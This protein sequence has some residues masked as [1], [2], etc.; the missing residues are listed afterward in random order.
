MSKKEKNLLFLVAAVAL[1]AVFWF[2]LYTPLDNKVSAKELEV[3]TLTAQLDQIKALYLKKDEYETEIQEMKTYI[4]TVETKFPGDM[5]QEMIIYTMIKL[6]NAI[7]GLKIPGYSLYPEVVLASDGEY[8]PENSETPAFKE[9]FIEVSTELTLSTSYDQLK[10]MLR[11]FKE[12]EMELSLKN[13]SLTS[14]AETDAIESS[15]TLN[16]YALRSLDRPYTPE[17]Y[18]GPFDPKDDSIFM[19]YAG[20]GTQV[21]S[22]IELAEQ[23]EP[24]DIVMNLAS[25]NSDRTS[26]VIFQNGDRTNET[27]LYA[28]NSGNEPVEMVFEN[29]GT[30]YFYRYKTSES[31]YPET[32]TGRIPFTPGKL[33]NLKVYV[34]ARTD[35][36]DK[37][38]V[39]A[40]LINRTDIPLNV[41]VVGDDAALPRF[42]VVSRTG[43]VNISN[44][45][46]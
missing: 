43:T 20:Y 16:Y 33:I 6:E 45:S 4:D 11:F 21:I 41:Q 27:Y 38:G 13:L 22:G 10:A 34:E 7:D 18:F 12:S 19:P 17:D 29:D 32:Y 15:F 40:T 8:I 31:S 30:N 9:N 23:A 35:G 44:I 25:I 2:L 39:N 42:N 5:T 14:N 1:F 36:N 37:N 3:Q 24:D 46:N 26:V 28:D